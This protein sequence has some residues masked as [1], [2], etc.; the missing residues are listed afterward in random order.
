MTKRVKWKE[1]ESQ[2]D[3]L[4]FFLLHITKKTKK[5]CK[6]DRKKRLRHIGIKGRKN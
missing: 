2:S 5:C 6:E 1:Q 4:V 3:N